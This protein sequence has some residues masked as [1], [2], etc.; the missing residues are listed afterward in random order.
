MGG[1][2][3]SGPNEPMIQETVADFKKLDPKVLVAGHCSGWRVKF[4]IEKEMPGRLAP[5]FVGSKYVF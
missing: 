1:Y 2:H 5:S 4:E 3:L